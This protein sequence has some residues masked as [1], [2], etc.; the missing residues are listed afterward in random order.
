MR[1]REG[2]RAP[3]RGYYTLSVFPSLFLYMD[4]HWLREGTG[5][6][7]VSTVPPPSP[8]LPP[9]SYSPPINAP[10]S[11]YWRTN[12]HSSL[13][14]TGEMV[15]KR[16]REG[17]FSVCLR[18]P[19]SNKSLERRWRLFRFLSAIALRTSPKRESP[20]LL[21]LDCGFLDCPQ[22]DVCSCSN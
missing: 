10:P 9:S 18:S 16:E 13:P 1:D 11:L 2:E 20:Y 3:K 4:P 12:T 14:L 22:F 7:G 19:I 8:S 17:G 5:R 21:V 15:P 6:R